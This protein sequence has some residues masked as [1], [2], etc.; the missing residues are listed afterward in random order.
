[1][2][3]ER[4]LCAARKVR[5]IF[6]HI[7]ALPA[8]ELSGFCGADYG[9]FIIAIIL[10]YR[11][12]FPVLSICRDYDVARGRRILD[13]GELLRGIVDSS[14]ADDD[15]DDQ[16]GVG[17]LK[18][19]KKTDTASALKVVLRSVRTKYEEKSVALEAISSAATGAATGSS[20]GE[21][22]AARDMRSTCPMLNGTL[23]QYIPLWAGQQAPLPTAGSSSYATSQTGS[24]SVMTDTLSGLGED[25]GTA[26]AGPMGQMG[27]GMGT[28][29]GMGMG[30]G[31]FED[32]PLLYHDLWATMTMGW[33]GDLGEVNMEDFG[34][35]GFGEMADP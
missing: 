24:S 2:T 12:S 28:G 22:W 21:D 11:L 8:R 14:P 10:A 16:D 26:F 25:A 5:T 3:A 15:D 19:K 30:T 31:A 13:F 4:L 23:D 32:K 34:N 6:D 27:L 17:K 18:A 9:R 7:T 35:T 1:V 20:G 33:A 29:M